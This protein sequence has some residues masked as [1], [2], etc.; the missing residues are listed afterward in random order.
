MTRPSAMQILH[1]LNRL[2]MTKEI[3]RHRK[4][5]KI[6]KSNYGNEKHFSVQTVELAGFDEMA[7]RLTALTS[8]NHAFVIRGEPL[9]GTNRDRC[10]RLI[11]PDGADDATFADA[12]R[13]WFAVDMDKIPC[14]DHVDIVDDPD[15]A[16]D[17]L[18]RCLPPETH[19]VA[20]WWQFTTSQGLPGHDGKLSARLWF[21][22]A[23]PLDCAALKRWAF[24]ANKAAGGKTVDP[25]LY[26]AVQPHYTARPIF[27]DMPD[28]V[29]WRYG[30]RHGVGE[31]V[32]L[33]IPEPDPDDPEIC[34]AGGFVGIGVDAFLAEIG[35]ERGFRGPMV[36]AIASYFATNGPEA[37]PDPIK[38]RLRQA[39]AAAPRGGRSADDIKRYLSDRHLNDI[40]GW[41][42]QHERANPRPKV[43]PQAA[44]ARLEA[45]AV[46]VPIGSERV[47]AVRGVVSALTRAF[48]VPPEL[49]LSLAEAWNEQ[50]CS[51]P[52]PREQVRFLFNAAALREADNVRARRVH[53]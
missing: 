18:V 9:P 6:I 10:R 51:P 11:Y 25:A 44:A 27:V 36:A 22:N 34:G 50:N 30:I 49:A 43:E 48:S 33:V 5:G 20:C 28:P 12:V 23:F 13:C 45:L 1:S 2:L 3:R 24:A 47:V 8:Q 15:G 42:R 53:R 31:T 17:F 37:N 32:S 35:G 29:P 41:V 38:A 39:I 19:E 14:P 21:L 7:T 52:L 26:N 46:A 16:I 4:T 40:I